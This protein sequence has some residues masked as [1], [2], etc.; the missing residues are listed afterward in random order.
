[1]ILADNVVDAKDA[2]RRLLAGTGGLIPVALASLPAIRNGVYSAQPDLF[3]G[4]ECA[5]VGV[6]ALIWLPQ[7]P[8]V[9]LEVRASHNIGPG[10]LDIIP[11]LAFVGAKPNDLSAGRFWFD[12]V[13][14]R[15]NLI[16]WIVAVLAL[17]ALVVLRG[18][19]VLGIVAAPVAVYF[20]VFLPVLPL[21]FRPAVEADL[22]PFYI[23]GRLGRWQ[24]AET[25]M[26]RVAAVG[27]AL[28]VALQVATA[29]WRPDPMG[30]CV[31]WVSVVV[32][33][34]IAIWLLLAMVEYALPLVHS[35]DTARAVREWRDSKLMRPP[36]GRS[37]AR[38]GGDGPAS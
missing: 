26:F 21:F 18:P 29:E 8:R 17:A 28:S 15:S 1:M 5:L 20:A 22:L 9:M 3:V 32:I 37:G 30:Q 33:V 7:R 38:S 12:E 24:T 11:G 25:Q 23:E 19:G 27:F 2:V 31:L 4:P 35:L 13:R 36:D 16:A 14:R 34:L 10:D 6:T